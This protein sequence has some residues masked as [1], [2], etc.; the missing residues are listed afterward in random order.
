MGLRVLS[1]IDQNIRPPETVQTV[2]K[3]KGGSEKRRARENKGEQMVGRPNDEHIMRVKR[4]FCLV[5]EGETL[6]ALDQNGKKVKSG[7]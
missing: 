1:V 2:R 4:E 7:E 6:E 5:D 3:H